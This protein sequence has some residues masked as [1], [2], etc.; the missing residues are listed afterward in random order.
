M[1]FRKVR[2]KSSNASIFNKGASS[3]NVLIY[4]A[5]SDCKITL[6]CKM[7][8]LVRGGILCKKKEFPRNRREFIRLRETLN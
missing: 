4:L 2:Y 6:H 8:Q 3:N 5:K 1:M 7:D